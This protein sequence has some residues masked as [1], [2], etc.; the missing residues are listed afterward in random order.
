MIIEQSTVTLAA[1]HQSR[2][3]RSIQQ[4][5]TVMANRPE[6]QA[7]SDS[8]IV[9]QQRN[10]VV[11]PDTAAVE[12]N[13]N[14]NSAT[15]RRTEIAVVDDQPLSP[16]EELEVSLLRRLVE[17]LTGKKINISTTAEL[18]APSSSE[19]ETNTSPAPSQSVG[20]IY[21]YQETYLEQEALQFSAQAQVVTADGQK[22]S[23]DL[24]LKMSREFY[25]NSSVTL[26][27]GEA[28]KDPLVINYSGEAASLASSR[29]S[30]DLDLD[31]H[32]DQIAMLNQGSGFLALDRNNDGVINDGSELFGA[33]S[34]DGFSELSSFDQ[35]GNQWIDEQDPVFNR[36]RIWSPQPDGSSRLLALSQAG[37]GAIY[38]GNVDSPFSL[39]DENNQLLGQVRSSG[40]FLYEDGGAGTL[41]Q[42]DLVV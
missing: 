7:S 24:Q 18:A 6:Q 27:T 1:Q 31:G 32:E 30:F 12:V 17:M 35:Q 28:L 38:L 15:N 33:Q 14:P 26:K 5:L 41:Q 4:S 3:Q 40:L 10:E 22:I 36:L 11:L 23:V 21:S 19:T 42:I 39:K 9:Q 34:G 16:P 20:V 2:E 8:A 29:F 37:I 13:L 25:Q